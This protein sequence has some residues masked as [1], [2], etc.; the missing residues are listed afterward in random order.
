MAKQ[1]GNSGS[2]NTGSVNSFNKGMVKDYTDIFIEEGL[3]THA[4]NAINN[5]HYGE[6][7][8]IGNEPSNEYCTSATY[9][10]IGYASNGGTRWVI[11]STNNIDSEI[12][13]FDQ[14]D[15]SYKVVINDKCLGFK[16][17]Y[18]IKAVTKENYD[19]TRSV[20]WQDNLNPDRTMNLD[21]VPYIC[22]PASED[23][24]DGEICTDRLDCDAIRLHPLVKQP[25]LN[26]QKGKG[27]GQLANG[28]YMAIVAYSENGVRL[29]DYSAPSQ[30]QALWIHAGSGSSLELEVSNLDEN[31]EEYEVGI[32]GMV[33]RQLLIKKLGYYSTDQSKISIDN[34]PLSL[35]TIP[36]IE[37]PLRSAIYE[38]SAGMFEIN[39]YLIRTAVT[40][41]PYFNYQPLANQIK[42]NW[43]AVE[44][45]KDYYWDGGNIL[46]YYRDEVYAFFIRWVYKTGAR[47]ASY[48]I[49]GRVP[50]PSDLA[51]VATSDVVYPTETEVWQV[52]DTSTI[53]PASGT[54]KDGGQIIKKG[55]MAYWEST[56]RYPVKPSI[57]GDLCNQPIR[58]HK[59]PSNEQIHIHNNGGS[60][61]NVLGVEFTGIQHPVDNNGNPIEDIVGYEILRG[62]REGN[63]SIVAKG[64]L[65]NMVE[66]PIEGNNSIKGM[67]ANYPWNDVDPDPFLTPDYTVLDNNIN[68]DDPEDS[69]KLDTYLK[70]YFAFDS[71][72]TD[73][74]GQTLARP[75]LKVYREIYGTANGQFEIPYK[76]PKFKLV[77]DFAFGIAFAVGLG[78]GIID[79]VGKTTVGPSG[80]D[81]NLSPGGVGSDSISRTSREAGPATAIG[82]LVAQFAGIAS[83]SGA[84]NIAS[85]IAGIVQFLISAS[86]YIGKGVDDVL[87]IIRSLTNF[88]DYYLQY[89]GHGFYSNSQLVQNI[90]VPSGLPRCIR[91][92]IVDAK[93]IGS[94]L[95]DFDNSYRINNVHRNKYVCINTDGDIEFPVATD[96]SKVK[97]GDMPSPTTLAFL[98]TSYQYKNPTG[99]EFKSS[100]SSYYGAIKVD[101]ENQYGQVDSVTQIPTDSCIYN[102]EPVVGLQY[103]TNTIFGG[104]V[105]IN[106]YT[107]KNPY[108]FFNTWLFDFPD[109]T[110]FDYPMFINGPAPRYW[111]R[112]QEF[113][114][115]D[116]N[117]Q[118][119]YTAPFDLDL[120]FGTPS[121]LYRLDQNSALSGGI[122]VKRY[123]WAYLFYNGVKDFFTESELNMAFRD[124]G[125]Q[126]F[127]QKF[128]DV[129]GYSF[130]DLPTM[131]RSDLIKEQEYRTYDLSLTA[132][133]LPV[134]LSKWG[135]VLPRDY[136]PELYE[137]CFEYYP[138]RAIYSLQQQS[139][140]KR[141]NWRNYLPLNYK[142]FGDKITTIKALNATG[143][144]MLFESSEPLMFT[145]VDQLQLKEGSTKLTIGD[146][147]LFQNNFQA[148]VNADDSLDYGSSISS[149]GAINTPF[150]LFYISQK[151][152]KILGMAGS[153]LDEISRNGLKFWF[154]E[155]LPSK[156]LEMYPDYP[157]YDNPVAG[158]GCQ[159]IFDPTYEL[160]YFT[161]KDYK[162]LR[163]DL[164]FDDPNGVPYYVCGQNN[165]STDIVIVPEPTGDPEAVQ[166]TL[167]TTQV[168]VDYGQSVT[169][170]WT[171]TNA[172]DVEM[173]NGIGTVSLNGSVTVSITSN[174]TYY[175][176]ASDKDNN[177]SVCEI[178]ITV[179]SIPI[180]CPCPYDD[181]ACFEPCDW[182]VSYD[183]KSKLWV[184][185]HDWHPNLMIPDYKHF[186]TIKGKDI[187]KH[188]ERWDSY[189]NFYGVDYPWE[190]E[191]P[192]VTPNSVT[193]LRNFEYTLDVYKFYN[194]GNDYFHIL[195]ENFDRA[196]IYNSE[197]ISGLLR[198]TLKGKNSPLD[199]I[200]KPTFNGTSI[201]ILYSKEE[202]KF[203]FN[204]F[205]DI[206]NDRGEFTGTQLPMWNT[207]CSGYQREINPAYVN[208]N[209][210]DLQH[211]KFRHYGNKV[212]LRKNI[213]NDKKMVLKLVNNKQNLSPR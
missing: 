60:R 3:W 109:G 211:K 196:I 112:Y 89:N 40:T 88:R 74:I 76:H 38:R 131:F 191:F 197:Q 7:G 10:I 12:G 133:R 213:S 66:F 79:A 93:Y 154:A 128:Y 31:F 113:D 48:H 94:H 171:T 70:N 134:N 190:V 145:G 14:S 153:S 137:T 101:Y 184:S 13:I 170:T 32:I 124:Y 181:P 107:K 81:V 116:F 108:A 207:K 77:T 43:V 68:E 57:W 59:M 71:P 84:L 37:V 56:E 132:S 6:T 187:W 199:L 175:I 87:G 25:C 105:Y 125:E 159:A 158:I 169:L 193:T 58:H 123:A 115:S 90:E 117:I 210:P 50:L 194:N 135:R 75:Y 61:I 186:Y 156:M 45:P 192:V 92:N 41:Q 140:L 165:P 36:N 168:N 4:I 174:T 97:V 18:L 73:F 146:A 139:G 15:C 129:Y 8:S 17:T 157:L 161:K 185:F 141:D 144:I 120:D 44:Y 19:C 26:L 111:A 148:I 95:Q 118:L 152:G 67:F 143:A 65:T 167:S 52:Y 28:S 86:F 83:I 98:G 103:S 201:D 2:L 110:E 164:V 151:Q 22:E 142:D 42:T 114:F 64:L 69:E 63:R 33:A 203:R 212:I 96:N 23:P 29:T 99:Y 209:K 35:E 30:A 21:N 53:G 119:V 205:W 160:I 9:D 102:T 162:P 183:P 80:N 72:E 106:R 5:S 195:D 206:T 180:K 138:K 127:T 24:C 16:K 78:I 172:T 85:A 204:Q 150:G 55:K 62:T 208:Y 176:V 104:D 179:N 136:D 130:N 54:E 166:C 189:A 155:H 20:Y 91:R 173:N 49:P 200:Q 100:I 202:N 177:S 149:R 11:F 121:D 163:D 188:N 27:A 46:G 178:E 1:K 47:S 147:G 82:D 51:P 34:I 198:L 39:D 122:F 182:T 126:G